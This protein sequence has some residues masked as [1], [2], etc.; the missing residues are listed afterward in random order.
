MDCLCIKNISWLGMMHAC[1][2]FICDFF[3][4]FE[5]FIF[6][7]LKLM[8][9]AQ[10]NFFIASSNFYHLLRTFVNSLDPDQDRH[11][12]GPDLDPN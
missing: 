5:Q 10:L 12:V 3:S 1:S 7:L 4:I 6:F 11:K 2:A 9:V 8:V